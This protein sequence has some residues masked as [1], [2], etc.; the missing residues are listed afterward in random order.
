MKCKAELT[1]QLGEE[2]GISKM[3]PVPVPINNPIQD[4]LSVHHYMA[5]APWLQQLFNHTW[6]PWWIHGSNKFFI[7]LGYLGGS[8]DPTT[9]SLHLDTWFLV[10]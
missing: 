10:T 7:T 4:V 8:M 6:I 9:V 1:G 5:S 3:V 2:Y